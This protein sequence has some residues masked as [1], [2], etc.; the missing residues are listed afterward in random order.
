MQVLGSGQQRVTVRGQAAQTRAAPSSSQRQKQQDGRRNRIL[1]SH[2]LA[3]QLGERG[4]EQE[5]FFLLW[6]ARCFIIT[7]LARPWMN[8][9]LAGTPELRAASTRTV[10]TWAWKHLSRGPAWPCSRDPSVR[11]D[12]GDLH[13]LSQTTIWGTPSSSPA[14]RTQMR[15]FDQ[16]SNGKKGQVTTGRAEQFSALDLILVL[17]WTVFSKAHNHVIIVFS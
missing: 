14:E 6:G 17:F 12:R 10:K 7:M 15:H 8:E 2:G 13:L 16:P 5:G 1:L 3:P 4:S 9:G 11:I